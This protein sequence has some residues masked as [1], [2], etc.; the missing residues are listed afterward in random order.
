MADDDFITNEKIEEFVERVEA[1]R[2]K[3]G[4]SASPWA[5]ARKGADGMG[6]ESQVRAL[7]YG[8]LAVILNREDD[9]P[10]WR[11]RFWIRAASGVSFAHGIFEKEWLKTFMEQFLAKLG[12][13]CHLPNPYDLKLPVEE[14]RGFYDM[15]RVSVACAE[16]TGKVGKKPLAKCDGYRLVRRWGDRTAWGG[17]GTEF[18]VGDRN[19]LMGLASNVGN[20]VQSVH[21]VGGSQETYVQ[22]ENEGLRKDLRESR[23][24]LEELQKWKRNADR[25]INDLKGDLK[26]A[27]D[28][29]C[30]CHAKV[31]ELQNMLDRT[32]REHEETVCSFNGEKIRLEKERDDSRRAYVQRD[33]HIQEMKVNVSEALASSYRQVMSQADKPMTV[34]LG[35]VLL[36]HL[37]RLFDTL[38]ENGFDF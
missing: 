19:L 15:L 2:R 29:R 25:E 21:A 14:G 6:I 33:E 11:I 1:L 8:G 24:E 36:V 31:Q 18:T 30:E 20:G 16:S 38:K 37:K 12:P 17:G 3:G 35:E 27:N 32:N 4:R 23:K 26:R 28:D 9:E 7:T 22:R 34:G 5:L 13:I 10:R